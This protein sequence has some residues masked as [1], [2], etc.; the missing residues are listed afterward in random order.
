AR[1]GLR[2]TLLALEVGL[3]VVLLITAGLLLKSY[4][5]LRSSDM[6]C[7]TQNVLT[8]RLNLFGAKYREPAQIDQFYTALLER[9]RALPGVAAAGLTEAIPGVGHWTDSGFTIL[10]HPPLPIGQKNDAPLRYVD[11]GYFQAIGI[12]ILSGRSIDPSK[13]LGQ[14][15]EMVISKLLAHDFFPNED[16]I[17]KH[18][19]SDDGMRVY[20]IVGIVGDARHNIANDPQ[21]TQ[22]LP[23]STGVLN[24]VFLVIRSDRDPNPLAQ[25]IERTIHSLDP[26]MPIAD[27]QTM[28]ELLGHST[29]DQSFNAT[30]L[31]SFA[32][33]SLL[34]AAAGLF[35]VLSYLVTQRTSEIGIRIA[36]GAQRESVLRLMLLDG[37]RPALIGLTLGLAASLGTVRLVRSML[38][39]TQPLDPMTFLAVSGLLLLVAVL[40]CLMP[41]WRASRLNPMQALRSE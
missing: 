15:N 7:I 10:E 11:P 13:H 35:G 29:A 12:P 21:P 38:Y 41:A 22:Y 39:G 8:M 32:A 23:L 6:G 4:Q 20:T 25:P 18:I 31:L 27:L 36:L 3:T 33:V 28:D 26:D 24:N 14:A 9:I 40:A 30:I 2:R 5:R 1:A 19:R 16:P 37:L 17:G 34:L